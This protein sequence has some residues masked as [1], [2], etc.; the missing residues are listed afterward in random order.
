MTISPTHPLT[1][2]DAA[3]PRAIGAVRL[4]V[5]PRGL[6]DLRQQGSLKCLFPRGGPAGTDAVLLN[7]AGGI[8][9][10]DRFA[11][12]AEALPGARLTI[13]TQAAERAYR[14]RDGAGRIDTD[15]TL[16]AGARLDWL[17][18]ET[19]LFEGCDLTRRLRVDMDAGA[20]ALLCESVIFGRRAMGERLTAAR[21]R[22]RWELRRA[23]Q[24]VYADAWAFGG[25]LEDRLDRAG[26]GGGHRAFASVILAAP[27]AGAQVAPL[28]AR[29]PA[30]GG[31]SE[32][33]EDI[34]ALRLLAPDGFALRAALLPCLELLAGRGLPKVWRL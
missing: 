16:G 22:D 2:G 28:R 30:T 20:T 31:V 25:D 32:I 33:C 34:V 10:G 9:G 7:T 13:S 6:V 29:L 8:T 26:Q 21:L 23:G 17:P 11:V 5:D 3:Q 19:I 15:L 1:A 27:G 18:Q 14:S 24:L 4:G 12:T